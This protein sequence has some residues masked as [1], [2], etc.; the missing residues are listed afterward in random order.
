MTSKK[1]YFIYEKKSFFLCSL[2]ISPTDYNNVM[3]STSEDVARCFITRFWFYS[4]WEM[5]H[6]KE[7]KTGFYSIKWCDDSGRIYWRNK[8]NKI[9]IM[10]HTWKFN[11]HQQQ[12]RVNFNECI[13]F[14]L[15]ILMRFC[16]LFWYQ[17][18][19]F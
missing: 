7:T 1:H 13:C 12:K 19:F 18:Y 5:H 16:E 15:I 8:K 11:T 14:I 10:M 6:N 2:L 4:N 17:K 3:K 9:Y